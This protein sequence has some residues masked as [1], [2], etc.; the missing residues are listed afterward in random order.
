MLFTYP[1]L[2]CRP[3]EFEIRAGRAY[4]VKI[5]PT[6][7]HSTYVFQTLPMVKRKCR[8]NSEKE[9]KSIFSYYTQKTCIY[10]C[11]LKKIVPSLVSTHTIPYT[12]ILLNL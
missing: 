12:S 9:E 11:T 8:L 6:Y 5:T 2:I 7:H 10:E 1:L 3:G 4:V